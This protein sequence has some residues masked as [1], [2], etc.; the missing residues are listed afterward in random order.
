MIGYGGH[1]ALSY[2]SPDLHLSLGVQAYGVSLLGMEDPIGWLVHPS[3]GGVARVSDFALLHLDLGPVVT[4]SGFSR[5]LCTRGACAQNDEV[6]ADLW[7]IKYGVRFHGAA[8]FGDVSFAIPAHE[9]W[10]EVATYLPMG[11][12]TLTLGYAF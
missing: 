12:P 5:A 1:G 4:G 9:S 8:W 3:L 10:K 7:V 6:Q 11:L 2:G